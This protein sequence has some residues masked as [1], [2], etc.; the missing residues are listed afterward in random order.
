MSAR[1]SRKR[2]KPAP[3]IRWRTIL[4]VPSNEVKWPLLAPLS[5][6]D[7]REVL[8]TSVRRRYRKGDSLFHQGDPGDSFHLLDRG[9]VAITVTNERGDG[10]MLDVLSPGDVFGEQALVAPESIRT[11]TATA[12]GNVETLSLRRADF[13]DLRARHPAVSDLLVAALAAQVRRLSAALLDAHTVAADDRVVKQLRRVGEI[14]RE[15]EMS[16][17]TVL[18]SQHDLASLAGTTRSTANRALQPL[19]AAGIIS[20]QRGRI[21]IAD[22]G[23]LP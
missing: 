5:E 19:V 16:E 18:L 20:L 9:H 6:A 23:R 17:V 21:E 1:S 7:R 2:L 13:V 14:F 22:I 15:P 4:R 10:V 12:V 11:A 3:P 8:R